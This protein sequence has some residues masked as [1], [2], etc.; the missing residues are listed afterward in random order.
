MIITKLKLAAIAGTLLVGGGVAAASAVFQSNGTVAPAAVVHP[1]ASV[2]APDAA[3]SGDVDNQ[4]SSDQTTTTA[5]QNSSK[6]AEPSSVG[7]TPQ[8]EP[9]PQMGKCIATNGDGSIKYDSNDHATYYD[10]PVQQPAAT[11]TP[12]PVDEPNPAPA[13]NSS[14]VVSNPNH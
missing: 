4:A 12:T 2:Q 14:T 13:D 7:V 8:P 6:A 9:Q 10:C 3:K 11:S 5:P 1:Q